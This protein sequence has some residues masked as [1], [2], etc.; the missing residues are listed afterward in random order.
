MSQ[1]DATP[2]TGDEPVKAG[3]I[4]SPAFAE[5][6]RTRLDEVGITA[7]LQGDSAI[8]QES[9]LGLLSPIDIMVPPGDVDR[10]RDII[11]DVARAHDVQASD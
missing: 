9:G 7:T 3:A 10:A 6:V 8:S 2:P 4:P 1:Q 11:S 5:E